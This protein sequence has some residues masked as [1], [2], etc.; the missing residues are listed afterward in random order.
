MRGL[1]QWRLARRFLIDQAGRPFG[2]KPDNPIPDDLKTHAADL[3]G[4]RARA[5]GVDRC[6]CKEP[7]GLARFL[8]VA[9]E[10][11]E[12]RSVEIGTQRDGNRHDEPPRFAT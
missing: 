5:P 7:A 8:A 10:A 3:G 6:Q 2:V 9:R 11:A 1:Q 4:L 12:T